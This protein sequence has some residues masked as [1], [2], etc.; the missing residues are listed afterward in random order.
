M[1]IAVPIGS[2]VPAGVGRAMATAGILVAALTD[3]ISGTILSAGRADII[4][5]IHATPDEFAWLDICYTSAKLISFLMTTWLMGRIAPRALMSGAVLIMGAASVVAGLTIRLDVLVAMRLVQGLTGGAMLVAGQALLFHMYAQ[6]SQPV[7]QA[8][9]AATAVVIPATVAPAF[10]GWLI[11]QHDWTWIVLAIA[12]MAVFA[13]GLLLAG[14]LPEIFETSKRSLDGLSIFALSL[15]AFC[16]VYVLIQGSRWDWFSELHIFLVVLVGAVAALAFLWR[17][18]AGLTSLDLTV[19][20]SANFSFAFAVSFVAGAALSGSAYLITAFAVSLLAFTPTDAGLLLVPSG[21][22]FVASLSIATFLFQTGRVQPITTVPFG[23]VMVMAAMWMLSGS[24]GDSGSESLGPAI[25]L[26]G[27]GL[28]FLFLSITLVAFGG[29]AREHL[30]AG[31]G[32]F[33]TGRQMGGLIGV[34]VLQTLIDQQTVGNAT[35]LGATL[36]VG[37]AALND[38]LSGIEALL[39]MRGMDASE[40]G[41]AAVSLLGRTVAREATV[42]AFDTAFLYVALLFVVAAPV[43]AAIKVILPRIRRCHSTT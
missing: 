20:R 10:H 34:A 17:S 14:N 4:G 3:A 22:A 35:V 24:S 11:D 9:F 43:L 23:I 19:F 25:V 28:G 2:T 18:S 6:R 39:M 13:K 15:A 21:F 1:I 12:P 36:N 33:D 42:I 16:M 40:A 7:L 5:D 38:R 27:F 26:R 31:I 8:C 30:G 41:R 37:R 29:L 32:I